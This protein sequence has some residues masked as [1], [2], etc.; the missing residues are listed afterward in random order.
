MQSPNS[1]TNSFLIPSLETH[2]Q[3]LSIHK[4]ITLIQLAHIRTKP[5]GIKNGLKN[6]QNQNPIV[7]MASSK[8][9]A[10]IIT[11]LDPPVV[12]MLRLKMLILMLF[13]IPHSLR[14]K[15]SKERAVKT[16]LMRMMLQ[17]CCLQ[18]NLIDP[19]VRFYLLWTPATIYPCQ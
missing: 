3:I 17:I 10:I 19:W 14:I 12:T 16:Q 1:P 15:T 8:F 6:H 2:F 18:L 7:K 4:L 11:M 9:P 13:Q 5:Q